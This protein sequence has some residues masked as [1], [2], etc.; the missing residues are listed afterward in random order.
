M[1]LI[2][3]KNK[4]DAH[5]RVTMEVTVNSFEFVDQVRS[6]AA[7]IFP[8]DVVCILPVTVVVEN[9]TFENKCFTDVDKLT[10]KSCTFIRCNFANVY[11]QDCDLR[12]CKFV[13]CD[14]SESAW[15]DLDDASD[16]V[17]FDCDF[18]DCQTNEH[19]LAVLRWSNR[20]VQWGRLGENTWG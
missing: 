2:T 6:D 11:M 3:F 8:D 16:S 13:E 20:T 14:F 15:D 9:Q 1:D 12:C 7:S 10:A 5:V 4:Y 18:K 19:M 17:V